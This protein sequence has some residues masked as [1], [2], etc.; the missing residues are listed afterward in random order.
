MKAI[1]KSLTQKIRIKLNKTPNFQ[2]I[3]RRNSGFASHK[4]GRTWKTTHLKWGKMTICE[5][6][7]TV[8]LL[9]VIHNT[10]WWDFVWSRERVFKCDMYFLY[11]KIVPSWNPWHLHEW[12]SKETITFKCTSYQ[13]IWEKL[14]EKE[15]EWS[16]SISMPM[17]NCAI[18]LLKTENNENAEKNIR[19]SGTGR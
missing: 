13:S 15:M 7:N 9:I 16:N 10:P 11:K 8:Q 3:S 5:C 4:S 2:Q 14:E 19:N 17:K 18:V 6:R 1:S 12:V